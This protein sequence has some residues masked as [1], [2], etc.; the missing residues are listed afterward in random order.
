MNIIRQLNIINN[1]SYFKGKNESLL[2]ICNICMTS[3]GKRLLKNRLLYPSTDKDVLKSRYDNIEYYI[4][5]DHYKIVRDDLYQI[6]DLDKSLRLMA[7]NILMPYN[8][9]STILSYEFVKKC[10]N[11]I[12]NLVHDKKNI[13]IFDKFMQDVRETFDFQKVTNDPIINIRRS[14]FKPNKFN[15]IDRIDSDILN[16]DC[17]I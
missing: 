13:E 3:M 15:D 2:S 4:R 5:D 7:L 14:I 6:N 10:L 16:L 9:Y 12:D 11:K 17:H 8:F 1:Y